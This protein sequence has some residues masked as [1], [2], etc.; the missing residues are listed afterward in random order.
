MLLFCNI[1]G[2]L[3]IRPSAQY[4][5]PFTLLIHRPYLAIPADATA[6][7]VFLFILGFFENHL[8]AVP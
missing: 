3:L 8:A 5:I 6:Q 2:T 4:N 1:N 7:G